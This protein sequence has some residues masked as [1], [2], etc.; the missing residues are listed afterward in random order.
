MGEQIIDAD[1]TGPLA[2]DKATHGIIN[3]PN[4]H[5][6]VH[7]GNHYNVK[8]FSTIGSAETIVFGVTTP[9][10]TKWAHMFFAIDG[11]T[12]TEVRMWEGATLSGGT[13]GSSFNNNRN[14]T[15]VSSLVIKQDPT[16]SGTSPTSGTLLS[17]SSRGLIGA[18]PSRAES[19]GK[20]E[21]QKE[22]ILASGTT[23]MWEIKSVGAGNIVD[24]ACRWYEHTDKT[25]Q[26]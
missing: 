26:F 18:T 19:A 4:E 23:Y 16:V 15:N 25:T 10:T 6:Q 7:D 12:Q 2:L 3:I 21:E 24:Y 9:N 1:G 11:T 13:I 8:N 17:A 22:W 14:S 20:T 5:H